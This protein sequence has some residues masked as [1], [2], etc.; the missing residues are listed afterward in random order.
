MKPPPFVYHR[1]GDLDEAL[2]VLAQFGGDAKVLAGGQ[3]LVPLMSMRLASPGHLVDI[4]HTDGLDNIRVGHD[5]VYVGARV[6]HATLEH[7]SAVHAVQPLLRQAL[8]QVAHP[9]IRNR[10]TTVGSL[11]HADPAGEMTGVLALLGGTVTVR[12][13]GMQRRIRADEFFLGPLESAVRPGELAVEAFFPALPPRT[14][15]AW[16]EVSRRNG[17]YAIC[18]VGALVTVDDELRIETAR[19]GLVSVG[20]TPAVV[21][22]TEALAGAP[23]DG[24]DFTAASV[25]VEAAIDPEPDIHATADYRRHLAGVL[26]ARA[27]AAATSELWRRRVD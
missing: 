1:P 23:A 2:D 14:G 19:V 24:V 6:R 27:L 17:D 11:V 20:P 25:Q 3:S 13:Q 9:T 4:N 18:G 10:G 8:V 5:G 26:T 16:L 7:D 12:S 15:T 21:D 22:V